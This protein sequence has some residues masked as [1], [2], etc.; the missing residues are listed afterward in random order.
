[1]E[2]VPEGEEPTL[3]TSQTHFPVETLGPGRRLGIWTQGC[4]LACAGC[5]SRHTWDPLGGASRTVSSL[6]G[7]WRE[8]LAR[9]A[10]GLT[11]S[12]GEPLDQPA[13][14]EALLA[15]AVR[16]RE[17]ATAPGGPAAGR[18]I[19]ILLYTGYEQ[20]E[21]E[22]DAAR[23]AAVRHADVLVTGR[24]RAAES[25]ALVWRGSANQRMWPRTAR[26]W[27]RYQEYLARTESGPRL[28]MV[29]GEG[30]V[31]LYGVPGRGELAALERRLRRAGIALTDASWRP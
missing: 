20:E 7:L 26:G 8:A 14:L 22:R 16:A 21:V 27:A 6:L 28:Q 13:A 29:E 4:G 30:D 24:F 12:G 23:S 2:N 18:E 3:R 1:M 15:G 25:T 19:D 17:E 11:V 5:M 10:D 31:R 9:G